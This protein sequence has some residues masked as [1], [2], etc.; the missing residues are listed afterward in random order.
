MFVATLVWHGFILI[1]AFVGTCDGR[2]VFR[3]FVFRVFVP[4][5]FVFM[6]VL[7][8]VARAYLP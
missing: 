1:T 8:V 7:F 4:L 3:V 5:L 6:S 2:L